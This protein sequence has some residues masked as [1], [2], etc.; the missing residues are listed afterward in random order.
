M[1]SMWLDSTTQMAKYWCVNVF[2]LMSFSLLYVHQKCSKSWMP[3]YIISVDPEKDVS[4]ECSS[5]QRY[6]KWGCKLVGYPHT[7][8]AKSD[9]DDMSCNW[10]HPMFSHSQIDDFS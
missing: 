6:L 2:V 1:D 10:R 5:K 9:A 8:Q 3:Y 7:N 4:R